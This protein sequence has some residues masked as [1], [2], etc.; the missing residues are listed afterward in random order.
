MRAPAALNASS[1]QLLV[2]A[3]LLLVVGLLVDVALTRPLLESK[4]EL[5]TRRAELS[6]QIQPLQRMESQ[7]EVM[8]AALGAPD[9]PKAMEALGR[10]EPVTM[11]GRMVA[12]SGLQGRELITEKTVV[13]TGVRWTRFFVRAQGSY[14]QVIDFVRRLEESRQTVTV[15]AMAIERMGAEGSLEARL[16]VSVFTP[17]LEGR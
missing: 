1:G 14:G 17:A 2:T 4:K 13:E 11:I 9:L 8:S 16:S 7:V 3:A 5:T 15:D 12:A 6:A 10:E